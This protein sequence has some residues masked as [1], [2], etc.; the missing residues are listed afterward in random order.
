MYLQKVAIVSPELPLVCLFRKAV[1][2]HQPIH[3]QDRISFLYYK[4]LALSIQTPLHSASAPNIGPW[5]DPS[6]PHLCAGV[7]LPHETPQAVQELISCTKSNAA[8]ECRSFIGLQIM[9]HLPSGSS[10]CGDPA[11]RDGIARLTQ[12]SRK[13]TVLLPTAL[14]HH[15]RMLNHRRSPLRHQVHQPIRKLASL[16]TIPLVSASRH[17]PLSTAGSITV[18]KFTFRLTVCP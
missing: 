2:C 10:G 4:H 11:S 18:N 13:N 9:R 7:K 17:E 12:S 1:P 8:V 16:I 14:L 5:R 6:S 15:S 3:P